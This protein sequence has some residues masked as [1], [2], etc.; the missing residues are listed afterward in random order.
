MSCS[1]VVTSTTRSLSCCERW[2][3]Q[4][5]QSLRDLVGMMAER[6]LLMAHT[7]IMRNRELKAASLATAEGGEFAEHL[8]NCALAAM[9]HL[10]E[11]AEDMTRRLDVLLSA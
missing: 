11:V 7:T 5:K 4:F 10:T 6:H 9:E 1:R 3:L 8:L 2:Y